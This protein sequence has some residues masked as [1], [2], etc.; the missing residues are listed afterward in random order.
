[1]VRKL[2]IPFLTTLVA[3][4]TSLSGCG[5]VSIDPDLTIDVSNHDDITLKTYFPNFGCANQK[6]KRGWLGQEIIRQTGY[7]VE[8]NQFS[9]S[10]D[11]EVNK[12]LNTRE[13]I[14]MLKVGGTIFNNYVT[15]GYFTD[16]TD[17]IEKYANVVVKPDGT[18]FKNLF[19]QKQWEACSYNG[20]I[21]AIPEIGHTAMADQAIVW[22]TDHLKLIGYDHIPQTIS[23]I[24]DALNKLEA[25]FGPKNKNYYA[26]GL[27]GTIPVNNPLSGAFEVPGEWWVDENGHLQNVI[28]SPQWE[29]YITWVNSLLNKG[30][31]AGDWVSQSETNAM[32]NF[33]KENCSAYVATYWNI[34]S[35]RNMLISTYQSFPEDMV[36]TSEKRAYV[37]GETERVTLKEDGLLGWSVYVK[38]DGAFGSVPQERGV[39]REGPTGVGYYI[40]VPVASC[41]RAAYVVDWVCKKNTEQMTITLIAGQEGLHYDYTTKD[42]PDAI[43]LNKKEETYVKI[44][45]KFLEDISGMSQ[46]QTSVNMDIAREWWPVAEAGFDAWNVLVVD[47]DGKEDSSRVIKNPFATHPVLP[48]FAKVDLE[49]QNFV[50]TQ[51]Q[52]LINVDSSKLKDNLAKARSTY[53]TRFYNLCKDEINAWY[54][55]QNS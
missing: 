11:T 24:D 29:K 55:S 3:L 15:L 38:G 49:A 23:E 16:L 35:V 46:F 20:R 54:A 19:T 43:K 27:Y 28:H 42:D 9:A 2:K 10:M 37:Y 13:P 44:Y 18:T 17:V 22:N 4:M 26:F 12:F 21:Y 33:V 6:I 45:D 52:A 48:K 51:A 31:I 5:A 50:I 39:V 40:T 34:T 32:N 8:F 47:E 1:M 36:L 25:Y 41:K 53:N 30:L 14:D 7:N